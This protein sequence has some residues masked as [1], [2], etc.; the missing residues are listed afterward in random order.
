MIIDALLFALSA[1][2]VILPGPNVVG[3]Y[4]GFRMVG[5]FL[6]MRGARQALSG[7]EWPARASAPL[8]DLRAIIGLDPDERDARVHDIAAQLRLEH[9]AG[10]FRRTAVP[11]A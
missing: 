3:Y 4:F 7:A 10:F 9:L 8:A 1:L 2:L 11:G 5:H 6:S